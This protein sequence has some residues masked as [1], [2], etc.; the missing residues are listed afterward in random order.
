MTILVASFFLENI[1]FRYT[2]S[3]I[4]EIDGTY[5]TNRSTSATESTAIFPVLDDP[6]EIVI[7]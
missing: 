2:L 7:G 3:P 4:R 1:E 5:R 6:W